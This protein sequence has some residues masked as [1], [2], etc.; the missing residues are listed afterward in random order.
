MASS[1]IETQA[2]AAPERLRDQ[3]AAVGFYD[4]RFRHGYMDD[5]SNAKCARIASLIRELPLP[6]YGRALDFG[7][8]TGM[9]TEVLSRALPGWA[10]EG[11]DLSSV[12]LEAAARRSSQCRFFP[13]A[14]AGRHENHYDL[15]FTHHVLEHVSDLRETARLLSRI[16]KPAASMFHALPCGNDGS[17]EHGVCLLR[18]DG[19]RT[20]PERLFFFEEEGH[21]RRLDTKGIVSLWLDDGYR[22]G[23]EWYAS[24]RFGAIKTRTSFGLQDVLAFADPA[25]AVDDRAR[26][27]LRRLRRRMA[28]LWAIRKPVAVVRYKMSHGCHGIRDR[29]LLVAGLAAY[30]IAASAE[31]ALDHLESREWTTRRQESSGGEMFIHL[32]RP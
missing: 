13:L 10:I 19:I 14:E 5:W 27:S 16:S 2:R 22:L 24:H 7:C 23:H 31:W 26:R 18:S 32:V 25:M 1:G 20:E 3:A 12:A 21:L 17:F 29:V 9:F 28:A 6:P 8:G 30:P 11:T 4:D 15:V